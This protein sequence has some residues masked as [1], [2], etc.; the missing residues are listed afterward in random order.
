LSLGCGY[1]VSVH[2]NFRSGQTQAGLH[3][4]TSIL[5]HVS[6]FNR[7]VIEKAFLQITNI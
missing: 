3:V 2:F 4:S 7:V 5:F 6:L 1:K